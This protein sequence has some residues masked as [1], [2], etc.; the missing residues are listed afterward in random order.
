MGSQTRS[1]L[2]DSLLRSTQDPGQTASSA[3]ASRLHPGVTPASDS[4]DENLKLQKVHET[5]QKAHD[6]SVQQQEHIIATLHPEQRMVRT[7]KV[8]RRA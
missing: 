6:L 1:G 3:A 8:V 5:S 2:S 4:Q 7:E